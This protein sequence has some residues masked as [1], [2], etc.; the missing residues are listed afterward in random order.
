MSVEFAECFISVDVE[1]AGPIPGEFSLLSIG[2]CL[3]EDEK[4]AFECL[5][6][7]IT[8]KADPKALE[9]CGLSLDALDRDGLE[10]VD[11]MSSFADWVGRVTE[12]RIP[13][14][15]GFNAGFD[16]S[17]VNYYFHRYLGSN[18]FG[19]APLDIKAL[20]MGATMCQWKDT[21]SSKMADA[22]HPTHISNHNALDDAIAQA[23]LFKLVMSGAWKAK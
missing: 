4:Q 11:A 15:V 5:L 3:V 8:R 22:L 20:F 6:K 16:W 2:A 23:E 10:A 21:R 19:F 17:F 12:G 14:F 7:P 13:V 18:P 9:V 1:T